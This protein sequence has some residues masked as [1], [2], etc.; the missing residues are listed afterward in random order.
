ML[1]GKGRGGIH[2]MS[3]LVNEGGGD[4]R[5]VNVDKFELFI[6]LINSNT[7]AIFLNNL[8]ISQGLVKN[9]IRL[10]ENFCYPGFLV[11]YFCQ[12]KRGRGVRQMSTPVNKGEGGGQKYPKFCQR[13]L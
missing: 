1:T 8:E 5:L 13:S 6:R 12:R 2:Q 9:L 3:T 7:K 4:Q 11:K 10:T